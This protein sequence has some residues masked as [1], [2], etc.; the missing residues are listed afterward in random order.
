MAEG[1]EWFDNDP[2][3]FLPHVQRLVDVANRSCRS[4]C[5][6]R[7]KLTPSP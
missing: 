4:F 3:A 1:L 7:C 2:A 5:S 6:Y